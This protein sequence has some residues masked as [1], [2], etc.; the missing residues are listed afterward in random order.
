MLA[1]SPPLSLAIDYDD[2]YCNIAA[3]DEEQI[4]L[5]LKQRDRVRRIRIRLQ[6][7]VPNLQ[8][9]VMAINEGISSFG[10]PAYGAS[11]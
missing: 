5:A 4:I 10:I 11:G 2:Q 8:K 1:H 6:I 9:V 3:E 7:P